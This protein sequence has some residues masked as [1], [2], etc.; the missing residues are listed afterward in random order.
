MAVL[1]LQLS[2]PPPG[3]RH[4]RRSLYDQ[5]RSAI[6]DGRLAPGIRLPAERGL[7]ASLGISRNTVVSVYK[8]L[9]NEGLIQTR[10]GAGTF[11]A[12]ALRSGRAPQVGAR[13]GGAWINP[14]WTDR[15]DRDP[16]APRQIIYNFRLGFPDTST[17]PFDVWQR[18]CGRALR[19]YAQHAPQYSEPA[20]R[21]ALREAIA[22]HVSRT[23]SIACGA[24][25]I[26]VTAGAQQ[27]FDLLA[28]VLVTRKRPVV[29][30]EDPGYLFARHAFAAVGAE[31]VPVPVDR[32]GLM[33]DRLPRNAALIYVTP[34]H[35]FPSGVTMSPRRRRAL[36]D[37]ASAR[38]AVVVEDDYDG[39]FRFLGGP[40]D[41]LQTLDTA[42][43]VFYVGTFSKS[44]FP[45]LRIGYIVAPEWAHAALA[46][47]RRTCDGCGSVI[48]QEA[49]ANFIGE[50]HLGQHVRRMRKIY[51]QRRL[52]LL[53]ALHRHCRGLLEPGPAASGLQLAV[54]ARRR[55]NMDRLLEKAVESGIV[56]TSLSR[57]AMEPAHLRPGF[58][59]G[60]GLIATDQVEPSITA[61]S[62]LLR[63]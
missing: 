46:R 53:E 23:R 29:A 55:W 50:G 45:S 56:I 9:T 11:I 1:E 24:G 22:V 34:S 52:A 61:L 27:A 54:Y 43:R 33:V 30:I 36:L 6:L 2:L 10:T 31:V 63:A 60:F 49:L 17:F 7:A 44:M 21:L 32:E 19:F 25:N 37:F 15:S 40:L 51:D 41:A 14:A 38:A 16:T 35:Q 47:A 4:I 13:P 59:L 48:E 57:L 26:I 62:R 20:G 42:D 39:E 5:L 58:A 3:S 18:L 8:I 28:R 12:P